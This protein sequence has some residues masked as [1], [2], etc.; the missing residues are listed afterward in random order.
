MNG[1]RLETAVVAL[2]VLLSGAARIAQAD[3]ITDWNDK[4]CKI[5]ASMGPGAPGHRVMAVV[6]VSVFE[7]VNSI[8][9]RYAPYMQKVAA[10]AGAS[11]DAAVAAANRTALLELL[12]GEKAAIEAAYQSAM[13][14]I[15]DGQAKVDGVAVG[16]RA[17]AMIL[18]RAAKDG[19]SG[20]DNYQWHTKPGVYVPTTVPAVPTWARRAPWV[21][22][23]ASQFRP[24]PPPDLASETWE[25]D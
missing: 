15:P 24:G 10:P 6:Q 16:E 9:S 14:A 18:A 20:P 17:A 2:A 21:M 19:A 1:R 7:A 23:K 22:E 11:V 5:V 12:P 8:D 4:A 13:A 25:K 3:V